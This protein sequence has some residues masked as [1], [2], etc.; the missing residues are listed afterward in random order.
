MDGPDES[1]SQFNDKSWDIQNERNDGV[2]P[3]EEVPDWELDVPVEPVSDRDVD[4][5][6]EVEEP[7]EADGHGSVKDEEESHEPG[8][9]EDEPGWEGEGDPDNL[10]VHGF[11]FVWAHGINVPQLLPDSLLCFESVF[12]TF[13]CLH[14]ACLDAGPD[15]L[16]GP[17]EVAPDVCVG[18]WDDAVEHVFWW[19]HGDSGVAWNVYSVFVGV[20]FT[21]PGEWAVSGVVGGVHQASDLPEL[22]LGGH[23]AEHVDPEAEGLSDPSVSSGVHKPVDGELWEWELP[24][25]LG[26]HLLDVGAEGV[27]DLLLV[28]SWDGRNFGFNQSWD[29][30]D[31]VWPP[32]QS[33]PVMGD[34]NPF[35]YLGAVL[36]WEVGVPWVDGLHGQL[37]VAPWIES[38]SAV[39]Q[40]RGW[41]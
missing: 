27:L 6:E 18:P 30:P 16:P 34:F 1:Q 28:L 21:N 29:I 23:P 19:V 4:L 39:W 38:G 32:G 13:W 2:E 9:Q 12:V 22:V 35:L 26:V 11:N 17:D 37:D 8:D 41:R 15:W 14:H 24:A 3:H 36:F 33:L 10:L 20:P 7:E 25:V 5:E 40:R 31:V